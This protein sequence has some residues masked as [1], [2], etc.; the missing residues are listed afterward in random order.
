M[1]GSEEREERMDFGLGT[2][3]KEVYD[4][5][6]DRNNRTKRNIK[7]AEKYGDKEMNR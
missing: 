5:T 2:K 4:E 1:E 7:E 6:K 3:D